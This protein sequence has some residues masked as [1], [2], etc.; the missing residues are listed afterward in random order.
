MVLAVLCLGLA[1]QLSIAGS[2]EQAKRMH[3][4]LAGVPPPTTVLANMELLFD[5][6]NPADHEAAA[7]GRLQGRLVPAAVAAVEFDPDH[8]VIDF[9]E[10]FERRGKP[11]DRDF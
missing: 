1:S 2:R 10:P 7:A 6:A 4:R 3:D 8:A 11:T 9:S 5:S